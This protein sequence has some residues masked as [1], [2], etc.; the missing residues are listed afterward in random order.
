MCNKGQQWEFGELLSSK[1]A[2][3]PYK[4]SGWPPS[5]TSCNVQLLYD[6]FL[7]MDLDSAKQQ[8]GIGLALVI[9]MLS[10]LLRV[11][12]SFLLSRT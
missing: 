9:R 12:I 6:L 1:P 3:Q 11:D 5:P 4:G 8:L 2:L 10:H 7:C